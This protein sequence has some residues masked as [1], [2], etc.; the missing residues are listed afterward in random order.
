MFRELR[1]GPLRAFQGEG[2]SGVQVRRAAYAR[3]VSL[4]E[5]KKKL[6]N[7]GETHPTG[8]AHRTAFGFIGLTQRD[9]CHSIPLAFVAEQRHQH[10][11][12]G[13]HALGSGDLYFY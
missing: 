11:V 6:L 7:D 9:C 8:D 13:R 3:C 4:G 2:V 10:D 5:L 12:V 1:L